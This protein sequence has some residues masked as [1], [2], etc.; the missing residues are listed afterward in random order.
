MNMTHESKK[1]RC[2]KEKYKE[3]MRFFFTAM[4]FKRYIAVAVRLDLAFAE[5]FRLKIQRVAQ[6][7]TEGAQQ[8]S[9]SSSWH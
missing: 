3:V 2:N 9:R 1:R 6:A 5:H 8:S 4:T 7:G